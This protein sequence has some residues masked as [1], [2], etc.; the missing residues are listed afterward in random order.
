[1]VP[2]KA[3]NPLRDQ[4]MV[5]LMGKLPGSRLTLDRLDREESLDEIF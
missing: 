2:Y 5:P 1:M 4:G 3:N